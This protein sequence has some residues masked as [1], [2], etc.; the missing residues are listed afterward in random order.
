[1]SDLTT[2][3]LPVLPLRNGIVFP[4]MVITVAVETDM[5]KK[6]LAAT[7]ATPSIARSS[8]AGTATESG[9]IR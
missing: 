9:R 7:E 1:M 8:A 6:A 3:S 4:H 5:A 2:T